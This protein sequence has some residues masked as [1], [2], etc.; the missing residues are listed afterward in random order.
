M[1]LQSEGPRPVMVSRS[2]EGFTFNIID[3]PGIV[4]GGYVNDQ[5]LDLIKKYVSSSHFLKVSNFQLFD[6]ICDT[7]YLYGFVF[8]GNLCIL[9]P[10]LFS[11]TNCQGMYNPLGM[12]YHQNFSDGTYSS[13]RPKVLYMYPML[14]VGFHI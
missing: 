1:I 7:F 6:V 9:S 14:F 5:A 3:T 11:W 4:E 12:Q 8:I 2:K 13:T 10:C